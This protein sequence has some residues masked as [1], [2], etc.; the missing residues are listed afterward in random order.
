M[1]FFT[2]KEDFMFS[3]KTFKPRK[4]TLDIIRLAAYTYRSNCNE[5]SNLN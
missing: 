4:Q 2:Q 5:K 3:K 1:K